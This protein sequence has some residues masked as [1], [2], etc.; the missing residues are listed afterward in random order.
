MTQGK[1]STRA[2]RSSGRAK[3]R[4][5][6]LAALATKSHYPGA[7][8]D[9]KVPDNA[10]RTPRTR[11][12]VLAVLARGLSWQA[13]ADEA[14]VSRT[15]L[16]KWYREDDEFHAECDAAKE[17]GTDRIEDEALR[18]GNN[19][20]RKAVYYQGDIVGYER[21]YSD[22]L[23]TRTLEARRPETWKRNTSVDVNATVGG[24]IQHQHSHLHLTA[25]DLKKVAAERGLPLEIFDK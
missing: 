15:S 9:R 24:V 1:A 7:D 2:S 14:E 23:L 8:P 16:Y 25:D 18:R 5:T 21:V 11:T 12:I 17:G 4:R 13:A 3:K 10:I 19:G 6:E 20:V 22:N